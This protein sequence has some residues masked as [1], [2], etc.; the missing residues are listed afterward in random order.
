MKKILLS[1]VL[2]TV[3]SVFSATAQNKFRSVVDPSYSVDNYKHP[4]K[5]AAARKEN[6]PAKLVVPAYDYNR[7]QDLWT[8]RTAGSYK[9]FLPNRLTRQGTVVL[10]GNRMEHYYNPMRSPDNYKVNHSLVQGKPKAVPG[11][12]ILVDTH[13]KRTSDD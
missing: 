7:M 4:N 5:A 2:G 12:D 8:P 13:E 9:H 10:P 6:P 3:I 1:V 11:P